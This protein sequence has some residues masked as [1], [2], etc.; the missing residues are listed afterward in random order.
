MYG[1]EGLSQATMSS[2]PGPLQQQYTSVA[3][4]MEGASSMLVQGPR[5]IITGFFD[6]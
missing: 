4:P 5:S 6:G 3:L 1:H 2:R